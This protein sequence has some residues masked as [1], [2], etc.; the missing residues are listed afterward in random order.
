[1]KSIT[2]STLICMLILASGFNA[3]AEEWT[4]D[5]KE[6]WKVI[7]NIWMSA[8]NADGNEKALLEGLHD[9][10]ICLYGD[11]SMLFDKDR[12]VMKNK[13]WKPT[14]IELKPLAINI[15]MNVANVFFL[16]KWED[17]K[18]GWSQRGRRMETLIK[19]N[20]RWLSIGN[21]SSLCDKPSACPYGW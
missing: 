15:V 16:F 20:D 6:V 21:F 10:F 2:I 19:E 14:S 8:K 7:D 5:Q 9:N 3:L 4:A 11:K 1:M 13:A 18:R 12:L 17:N